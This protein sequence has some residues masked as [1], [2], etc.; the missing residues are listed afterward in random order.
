M[1]GDDPAGIVIVPVEK[2]RILKLA[3][4]TV[5]FSCSW[6]AKN[7]P[8]TRRKITIQRILFVI[9]LIPLTRKVRR[10]GSPP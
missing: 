9:T 5:S 3:M 1:V 8:E 7:V 4:V 2:I 10:T 6:E